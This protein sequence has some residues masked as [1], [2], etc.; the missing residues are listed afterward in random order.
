MNRT[1]SSRTDT[2]PHQFKIPV[3]FDRSFGIGEYATTDSLRNSSPINSAP[4]GKLA[5]F[6]SIT[7]TIGVMQ[8]TIGTIL[9][10][11]YAIE[12]ILNRS[13]FSV[14]FLARNLNLP[15]QPACVIKQ[16]ASPSTES[17]EIASS[18]QRFYLEAQ[19]LSKLGSHALVP[20]LLDYFQID[21]ALYLVEEYIPG[22][23]L[24][25]L[26]DRASAQGQSRFTELQ[27][28]DFLRQMLQLLE[29]IHSHRLIHRDIK[30]QNI[31][32]CQTDRRYVLVDFGAVKDLQPKPLAT[33]TRVDVSRSI[34]TPGFAPPE[35]LANRAVY[36]SDIYALGMTCVYLLTGKD[37]ARLPTDPHTCELVW[38]D[39]LELSDS[40]IDIISKT[41]QVS[42]TDRYQ[43]AS[44]VLN[45]L[46]NRSVRA[47]LKVYLDQRYAIAKT[48]SIGTRS[49]YPAAIDWALGI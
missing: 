14:T 41:I 30:P 39:D 19:T 36:A 13:D 5:D 45:A 23:V 47:T 49:G 42:L 22:T 10:Q 17:Q 28:E 31:I 11:R 48:A 20:M 34:G 40:T 8:P 1:T 3:E 43:S 33:T 18:Q 27:I 9:A 7:Q 44:E 24:S 4:S 2:R 21:T 25:K 15:G 26:L 6:T 35:Q 16:L 12:S 32:L 38:A 37:P 46:D 29:Y